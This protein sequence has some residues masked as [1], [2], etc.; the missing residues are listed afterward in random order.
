MINLLDLDPNAFTAFF[1]K[2]GEKPF[3][4]RQVSRWLHQRFVD[5]VGAM[6]DLAR[7]L[8]ER[9]A[10]EADIRAPRVVGDTTAADGTRKWLIDAGSANAIEAV[11][12]PED[13]RGT[14]CVSSQAGCALDCAFCSTGKQGFNRNL[15]TGEIIGQAQIPV[16]G[17]YT[18]AC[19]WDSATHQIEDLNNYLSATDAAAYDGPAGRAPGSVLEA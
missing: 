19:R 16:A 9:L 11:Y 14:L 3:R 10:S 18:H 12:I 1:A 6:S 15:S 4:A 7:P 2:R 13:D 8:R 17:N 5:D